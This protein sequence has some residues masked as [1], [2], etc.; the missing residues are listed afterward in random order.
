M[1]DEVRTAV[2][3]PKR[4]GKS[5]GEYEMVY[6]DDGFLALFFEPKEQ[7]VAEIGFAPSEDL[8]LL[9]EGTDLFRD[10]TAFDSV[11]SRH[12]K[13][14]DA[15]G[16]IVFSD[17]GLSFSGFHDQDEEHK[18]VTVFSRGRWDEVL[19]GATPYP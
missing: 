15:M 2:G 4:E 14:L 13:A 17:L 19:T 1:A 16:S 9:F 8:T 7:K 6:G 10:P 3:P 18:A 5:R 12:G 11:L